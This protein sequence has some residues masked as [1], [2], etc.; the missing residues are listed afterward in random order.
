MTLVRLC[1]LLQAPAPGDACHFDLPDGVGCALF[2]VGGQLF[3]LQN[4]CPHM[5]SPIEDGAIERGVLTCPWHGW[6]F[7]VATGISL[8]SDH[9]RIPSYPV[10]V[11]NGEVFVDLP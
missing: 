2:N 11:E 6:Q 5:D 3:A 8:M 4:N 10:H 9:I 1:Q 7:N